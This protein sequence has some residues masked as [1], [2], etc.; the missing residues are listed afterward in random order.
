V[1]ELIE[2]KN[3]AGRTC[4]LRITDNIAFIERADTSFT[5]KLK[6]CNDVD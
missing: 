4:N 3:T 1:S 6:K 2:K 5:L